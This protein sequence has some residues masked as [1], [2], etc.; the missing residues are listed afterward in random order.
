MDNY[1][2][3]QL[4]EYQAKG[5]QIQEILGTNKAGGRVTY[6]ATQTHENFPV[7]I[8]EFQFAKSQSTWSDYEAY[9][10]EVEVLKQLS[11]PNIPQYLDNIETPFGFALVQEYKKA[12]PLSQIEDLTLGEI[13]EIATQIL[14]VLVYLQSHKPPI[15][16]RDIKPENIL[17]D[18]ND[19]LEVYLIDFGFARKGGD[20]MAMSSVV[21]GTMGF[22]PPEQLYNQ[23][24]TTASDLYSLGMTIISLL[25]KIP[26]YKIGE[27]IDHQGRLNYKKHLA[28]DVNPK[29]LKWLDQMIDT[30][31]RYR[32]ANAYIAL[33]ELKNIKHRFSW[34][35][36]PKPAVIS[37]VS[38]V[39]GI[40]ILLLL[41]YALIPSKP[42][43]DNVINPP[44]DP[45]V[46][47]PVDNNYLI[48]RLK[49]TKECIRCDLRGVD[50]S[51]EYLNGVNLMEANLEGANLKRVKLKDANLKGANL[52][53]TD[54]SNS[55]LSNAKL[56]GADLENADLSKTH[57][58]RANLMNANLSNANLRDTD[59]TNANLKDALFTNESIKTQK[60][61]GAI[62][63]PGQKKKHSM[64]FH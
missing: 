11:Y 57:F 15:F 62:L 63:P 51:G 27:L 33:Q 32:F 41:G 10:R 54:L 56:M 5:Y 21:K 61:K 40:I 6:L 59:F 42:S 18:R 47:T 30:N 60:F 9:A 8:K 3:A 35:S 38:K 34:L 50:L 55:D 26:S 19:N 37:G 39:A 22:M 17:V 52:S 20:N 64:Q 16:H 31:L 36:M 14:E 2:E 43:D 4:T 58:E 44:I 24:L 13:T 12:I 49:T 1:P 23:K 25:T 45:I 28:Y 53:N 46:I 48:E 7:V 29:F